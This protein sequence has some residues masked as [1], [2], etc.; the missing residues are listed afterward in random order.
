MAKIPKA[1]AGKPV[2]KKKAAVDSVESEMFP[3][4]MIPRSKS[5][6][7][8]GFNI[9]TGKPSAPKKSAPKK[10]MKSGG[11]LKPVAPS[12]KK[13]L[14]QLPEAVRNQMGYQKNGGKASKMMMMGG[15]CKYGC[16]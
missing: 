11:A 13:S 1:Q 2:P 8:S 14:G 6:Y 5:N 9:A 7:E 12:K 4:K 10:K 15:K 3:G 16:K